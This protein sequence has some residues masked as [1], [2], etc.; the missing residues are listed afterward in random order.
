MNNNIP[1]KVLKVPDC[2]N[3][4]Q[5]ISVEINLKIQKWLVVAI[6]TPSSQYKNYF[7]TELAK[8]LDKYGG[9]YEKLYY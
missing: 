4:I 8:I 6:Y 3:D 2:P 9:S 5:V 7:I 1:S